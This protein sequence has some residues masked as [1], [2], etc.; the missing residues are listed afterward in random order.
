MQIFDRARRFLKLVI[1]CVIVG[2][3]FMGSALAEDEAEEGANAKPETQYVPLK[4]SFVTNYQSPKLR[5]FKTDVTIVAK[6]SATAD[7]INRHQMYIRHKLVMLFSSQDQ[8]TLNSQE[9]KQQLQE[10]ALNQVIE[11]LNEEDEPNDVTAILFTSFI[12]E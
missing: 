5:Y 8:S 11:V 12:V 3:A 2:S 10:D 9:G 7:A 6:G 4:P 1:L